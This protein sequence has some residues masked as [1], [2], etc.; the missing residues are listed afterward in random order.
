MY[1]A[2]KLRSGVKVLLIA[3]ALA[4]LVGVYHNRYKQPSGWLSL[5]GGRT[6]GNEQEAYK[7]K[8]SEWE[9]ATSS[10]LLDPVAPPPQLVLPTTAAPPPPL[11][12][13]RCGPEHDNIVCNCVG[14]S[15]Y[16]SAAG[17]C[18]NTKMHRASSLRMRDG[19]VVQRRT[20]F[21][22]QSAATER[23]GAQFGSCNCNGK[24]QWCAERS[25][26]CGVSSQHR[27]RSTT[28]AYDCQNI[29]VAS[30]A[31]AY[32]EDAQDWVAG[33]HPLVDPPL[34][35]AAQSKGACREH[36]SIKL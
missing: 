25:G 22:C 32:P 11:Q 30:V 5:L 7:K 27:Q 10:V 20:G 21:D 8:N 29:S 9:T 2:S 1:L 31:A 14:D 12:A 6:A 34:T 23:C 24:S 35:T 18:G 4:L 26:W 33:R 13:T 19:L 36:V 17:W 16:C 3:S 28:G 15:Q